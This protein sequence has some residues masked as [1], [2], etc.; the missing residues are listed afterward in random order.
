MNQILFSILFFAALATGAEKPN[1]VL[2]L[3]NDMGWMETASGHLEIKSLGVISQNDD[4][5]VK[6]WS[7]GDH[8]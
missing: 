3:V 1:G 6:M 2:L 5:P 8:L 4:K 7:F